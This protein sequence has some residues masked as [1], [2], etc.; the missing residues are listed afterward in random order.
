MCGCPTKGCADTGRQRPGCAASPTADLALYD[1]A[2]RVDSCG[3]R[4]RCDRSPTYRS[5]WLS[6]GAGGGMHGRLLC[7][8]HRYRHGGADIPGWAVLRF[9]P[10]G[11][12]I[13]TRFDGRISARADDVFTA[14]PGARSRSDPRTRSA[15]SHR[16]PRSGSRRRQPVPIAQQ[17][18]VD[19]GEAPGI[20]TVES[21][22]L[23][24]A[25]NRIKQ[26]EDELR[27][28]RPA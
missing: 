19:R 20:P 17:A 3:A 8:R 10:P 5:T 9:C 22:Q 26:L 27:A 21:A 18:L 23:R 2:L 4:S 11:C 28:A 7:R 15:R 14:I 16:R 25:L 1:V 12:E 6:C 13:P 24:D